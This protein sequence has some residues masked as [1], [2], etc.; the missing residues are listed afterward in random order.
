V[1]LLFSILTG[2]WCE[3]S[4]DLTCEVGDFPIIV[5]ASLCTICLQCFIT[6][7]HFRYGLGVQGLLKV[8]LDFIN[9]HFLRC[10]CSFGIL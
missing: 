10:C 1:C 3:L 6:N 8:D 2:L 5:M 7:L 9:C 4:E